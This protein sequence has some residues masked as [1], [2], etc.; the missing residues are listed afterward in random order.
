M[1]K[2]PKFITPQFPGEET[3]E[4]NEAKAETFTENKT[5]EFPGEETGENNDANVEPH[6]NPFEEDKNA[7]P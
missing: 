2:K 6:K 1:L 5:P 4:N 3:G 7:I